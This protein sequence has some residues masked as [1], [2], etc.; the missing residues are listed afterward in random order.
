MQINFFINTKLKKKI[1]IV[2][3][4]LTW[5]FLYDSHDTKSIYDPHM[6]EF[7]VYESYVYCFILI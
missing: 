4:L 7:S 3:R 2:K 1:D 6:K 5:I